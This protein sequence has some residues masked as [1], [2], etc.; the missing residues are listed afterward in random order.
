M[1]LVR[2]NR[3]ILEGFYYQRVYYV[4]DSINGIVYL[5][6]NIRDLV[7]LLPVS[8]HSPG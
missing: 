1:M 7:G 2:I 6:S 3:I 4:F 8:Q 5:K